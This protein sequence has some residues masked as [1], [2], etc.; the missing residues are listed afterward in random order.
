[1][2]TLEG[3]PPAFTDVAPLLAPRSIAVIGASDQPGNLGGV[4]IKLLQRFKYPGTI[5]PINPKRP[6]V[7]G[8]ACHARVADLPASADLAIFATAAETIPGLVRECVAA[9]IRS[10][11]AWAGGFAEGGERGLALQQE[12]GEL[13]R[14]A[15]FALAGP[16]C[17]GIINTWMPMTA[18][19][20]SFLAETTELTRGNI[21]M[22]SQSGGLATMAQALAQQAGFGFRYMISS[23]NEA[24]LTTADYIHALANDPHTKV[25]ATYVEGIRDGDTFVAALREARDAGKPVVVLKGGDTPASARAAAAHTGALAGERRVWDAIFRDTAAIRVH[26]L[27][28]LLDTLLFLSSTEAEKLPAGNGVAV[29]TFGGGSGVLAADQC[30]RNGLA[31][32]RLSAATLENLRPLVPAIAA[33]ENPIDLTPLVYNQAQWFEKFGAALDTIAADPAI[34]TVLLQFGP[35]AQRGADVAQE[36]CAFRRRTAKTVCIAWPLAPSVV[37]PVLRREGVHSFMEYA[38]AIATLGRLA[39]RH[40]Q[41]ND[42]RMSERAAPTAFDWSA[43]VPHAAPG[44]VIS[45]HACHALLKAAGLPVAA[46]QLALSEGE[47]V[48]MAQA[49]GLPVAMKGISPAVTHRAAAGLLALGVGSPDD[50]RKSYRRLRADAAAAGIDLDGIYVQHMVDGGIEVLVS[51]FRDPVFGPMVSV[52]AGGVFTEMIDDVTFERAPVGETAALAMIGRLRLAAG[53]ARLKAPPDQRLLAQFVA[54]FSQLA[55]GA[56]YRQFVLEVNPVKWSADHVT[57]VDGLLLIEQP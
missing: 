37:P 22:V 50:V 11:I 6:A 21:S 39:Q 33:V 47:A 9:G 13:C 24:V 29:I 19:F 14:N 53:A 31:T 7:H 2:D 56:P 40:V 25:I 44:A 57:A 3:K 1:V 5:W 54:R 41:A 23:G 43:H 15:G 30:A 45:E 20:A 48:G 34:H 49:V 55:A 4:A 26:S 51:A 28:E 18:S 12:I 38:R 17:I 32:P 52:G 16:N 35:Q 8:I 10:G 36:I 27:E 42:P 46:G